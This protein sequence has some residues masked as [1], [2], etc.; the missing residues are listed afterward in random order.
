MNRYSSALVAAL[1][2]A[3]G[4]HAADSRRNHVERAQDRQE[5][6]QDRREQRDDRRD[7]QELQ[8]VLNRFDNAWARRNA[9]E[10]AAVEDTLHRLLRAELAEGRAELSADVREARR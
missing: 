10:M 3:G 5:V 2:F 4:A 9:R 8:A 7:V 1:L 6:R